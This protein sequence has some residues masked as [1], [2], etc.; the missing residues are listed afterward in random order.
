MEEFM[1]KFAQLNGVNAKVTLN[2]CLFG[3][4]VF[5]CDELQTVNYDNRIG[6]I[7][8]NQEKFID[9]H[10]VKVAE[11]RNGIYVVSDGR[12]TII[13]EKI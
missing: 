11:I 4:Q 9:K 1:R 13:I 12:F 5:Y 3:Q 7:I 6:V 8:K 2:H 10:N